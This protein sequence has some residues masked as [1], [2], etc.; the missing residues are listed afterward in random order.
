MSDRSL[1]RV[2]IIGL[3]ALAVI[4]CDALFS[5]SLPAV[6]ERPARTRDGPLQQPARPRAQ[7]LWKQVEE[8]PQ[9]G[10]RDPVPFVSSAVTYQRTMSSDP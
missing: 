5:E 4:A 9:A 6:P 1:I 8:H 3:I 2:F 7:A 10:A